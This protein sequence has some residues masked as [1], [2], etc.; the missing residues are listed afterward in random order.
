MGTIAIS[1]CATGIGAACRLRLEAEGQRSIGIDIKDAEVIADLATPEGRQSAIAE[2]LERSGGALDRVLL[3][4]GLGGH[5][6][7]NALVASVNYFGA[8]ELLDGFLPAL[9]KGD[10]PA[11]VVICSNSAQIAPD[12]GETP[13]ARAMLAGDEARAR[14][15]ADDGLNGQ[16]V[17][18]ISKH[19]LGCA[20]RQ[21]SLEWGEAGVRLNAVAPGPV[22]TPLLQGGLAT[23]GDGD[24]IRAFKVPI[25]RFGRP[26]EIAGVVGF[27]LGPEAAFVHGAIWYVDGGADANVRPARF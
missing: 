14:E 27:L 13:L 18:M 25:G 1:G 17:Y 20:V 8:V 2:T 12:L 21:R 26:E 10:Q 3:C 4:A 19:A 23:P 6:G 11:A 22:D 15:L 9:R 24:L 5:I 7:K 16:S